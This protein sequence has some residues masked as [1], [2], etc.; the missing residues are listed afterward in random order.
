M[1][2]GVQISIRLRYL[3]ANILPIIKF[4]QKALMVFIVHLN[5]IIK[6]KQTVDK[7]HRLMDMVLVA[8]HNCC[9]LQKRDENQSIVTYQIDRLDEDDT[10]VFEVKQILFDRLH[11]LICILKVKPFI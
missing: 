3:M 1:A 10:A 6:L 2:S 7:V 8:M 9:M 11:I 4:E 5:L